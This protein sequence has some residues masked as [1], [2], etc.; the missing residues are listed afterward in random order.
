MPKAPNFESLLPLNG[1][2]PEAV[3]D[4]CDQAIRTAAEL[5]R[6]VLNSVSQAV[7]GNFELASKLIRCN[8]PAEAMQTYKDWLSARRDAILS[9]GKGIAAQWMKLYDVDM[10]PVVAA[11]RRATDQAANVAPMPRAAAA[12]D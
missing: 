11:A 5:N 4:Y 8:D 10:T 9:D 12:G 2:A 3:R 6:T 1:L 7:E